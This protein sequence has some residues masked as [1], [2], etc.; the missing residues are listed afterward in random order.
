MM[1]PAVLTRREENV[2]GR[3]AGVFCVVVE[4]IVV[5]V[6]GGGRGGVRVSGRVSVPGRG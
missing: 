5:V 2:R 3:S 1:I 6:I 4:C